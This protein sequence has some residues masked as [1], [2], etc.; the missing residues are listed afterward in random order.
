M[1]SSK[2]LVAGI[3]WTTVFY[4]IA[5]A[6]RFVSSVILSRILSPNIMG[7][8]V[9]VNTIRIGAELFSDIGIGQNI[10]HNKNGDKPTFFNTAWVIQIVR[11]F[12]LSAIL[13]F[14]APLIADYYQVDAIIIQVSALTLAISGMMSTS[15]YMLQR[16]LRVVQM[17]AFELSQEVLASVIAI[18]FA[19]YSPTIWSL[20]LAN[21]LATAIRIAS[22][23][24]LLDARQRVIFSVQYARQIVSFGKWITLSSLLMFLCANFDRLYLAQVVPLATL[25]VYGIARAIADVPSALVNRLSHSLVFPVIASARAT[26]LQ[27]VR[28]QLAPLRLKLLI[29]AAFMLA[30]G[31]CVADLVIKMVYDS[32]Y[33]EAAWMLPV[34][35]GGIWVTILASLNEYSLLGLGRPVYGVIGNSLKL[36]YLFVALPLAFASHGAPGV[37]IGIALAD[38]PRLLT[39]LVGQARERFSFLAQDVGTTALLIAFTAVLFFARYTA[40]FGSSLEILMRS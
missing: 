38:L 22:T 21:L 25:G 31:I 6:F 34:L 24:C 17:S 35:L 12:L 10:I 18:L 30:S 29:A 36:G 23:Y 39:A 27:E 19:L 2:K 26:P 8:M 40:G 14:T 5:V 13:I 28:K 15:I 32:R 33:V 4:F 3:G 11:G 37:V 1:I 7:M 16:N 9:V 20:I